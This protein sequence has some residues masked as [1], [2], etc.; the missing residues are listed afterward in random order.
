[1]L[2]D[3]ALDALERIVDGLKDESEAFRK[4]CTETIEKCV[5]SLGAADISEKMEERLMRSGRDG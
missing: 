5:A 4:M 1:M 3:L 2:A